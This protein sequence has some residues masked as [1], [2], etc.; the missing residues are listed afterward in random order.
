[1]RLHTLASS[2]LAMLPAYP[3]T[4]VTWFSCL[5]SPFNYC[6]KIEVIPP[7]IISLFSLIATLIRTVLEAILNDWTIIYS[8]NLLLWGGGCTAVNCE[9]NHNHFFLL[10]KPRNETAYKN[11]NDLFHIEGK[12]MQE[13]GRGG[14]PGSQIG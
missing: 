13:K 5:H 3:A 1:M 11:P 6:F 7:F 9:R 8:S 14:D 4:K 12:N 10:K 2:S